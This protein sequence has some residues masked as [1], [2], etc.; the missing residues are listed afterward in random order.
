MPASRSDS[1]SAPLPPHLAQWQLPPGW[2]WGGDSVREDQR[3]FQEVTDA[4]GRSLSLVSAPNPAHAD[5]LRAEAR[6]LAHRNHPA[7]PTTYHYWA[8]ARETRRGPG[9]LRR[10]ISGEP[11][12]ERVRRQGPESIPAALRVLREAGAALASVHDGGAAHG[13]LSARTVYITPSGRLWLLGWQW[14]VPRD[15][16]PIG[17]APDARVVPEPPERRGQSW[18]ATVLGDQWLLGALA[19]VAL[20]GEAPPA[21]DVPPVALVRPDVPRAAADVIERAL[22]PDPERRFPSVTAMVR[23]LDR[24][25]SV[26]PVAIGGPDSTGD[27][28]AV[29]PESRLRWATGDDYD[30]L[31]PL[32]SG[33]FGA[34][35]RVR[36]L[37]LGREVAL[38]MLH[39]R[40]ARDAAAVARFRRE[41]TLAAQLAHPAIVPIFDFEERGGTSWYT[42]ELAEG[43]SVAELVRRAGPRPL[44]EVAA[45]V[46]FVL[47]GLAAAHAVGVVHRDLKPE[48]LLVDRYRRWRVADF[49]IAAALGEETTGNS[50]TPAFAPPEQLLGEPQ[51]PPADVFALA[52]IVY[53]VLLGRPPF[54]GADGP[55]VL[56]AQLAAPPPFDEFPAPVAEWLRTALASD[57]ERRFPDAAAALHA[58]RRVRAFA[59]RVERRERWWRRV[60]R[61][62]SRP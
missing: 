56:A 11:L 50:G 32:G 59:D 48:N 14:A 18:R 8:P 29:T 36:D 38:K 51:G 61:A 42:M 54:P 58:W 35:W 53:A 17:M 43:G 4:L 31:A 60:V 22:D 6:A 27:M 40:V 13:G 28:P 2:A 21:D 34:V 37:Q 47:E 10:W 46:D 19:F 16:V 12:A 20:T 15:R 26:R 30:I 52:A 62:V 9:Y 1:A 33:G 45:Q 24:G 7:V 49:G 44:R 5:W 25:V 41:A 55:A 3:H 23:A 57:P 39:P